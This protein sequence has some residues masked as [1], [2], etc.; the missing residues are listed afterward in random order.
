MKKINYILSVIFLLAILFSCSYDSP[1]SGTDNRLL[2]LNLTVDGEAYKGVMAKGN[3]VNITVPLELDLNAAKVHY[4]IS[5]EARIL[6]DP[7]KVDDWNNDQVFNVIA[8]NGKKR[9]YIVRII[10]QKVIA[11]NDVLLATDEQVKEF[12]EKGISGVEGNLII[13]RES[14]IDSVSNI[15]A[16]TYLKKVN[17]KIIVNPTY[18]GKDLAGLRNVTEMGGLQIIDNR[19]VKNLTLKSLQV[20][21]EDIVIKGDT[22]KTIYFPE[23]KEIKGSIDIR[24]NAI[25]GLNFRKL[26]KTGN[27]SLR[28]SR[29]SI[30]KAPKMKMVRGDF[31]LDKLPALERVDLRK[32]ERIDGAFTIMGL[33]RL[34]TLSLPELKSIGNSFLMKNSSGISEFYLMALEEAKMI[35]IQNNTKLSRLVVPNLKKVNGDFVITACPLRKLNQVAVQ[36]IGG[37]LSLVNLTNIQDITPFLKSIKNVQ[38]INLTFLLLDG[39]LDLSDIVFQKLNIDN[40][41]NLVEIVLPPKLTTFKLKGNAAFRYDKIPNIKGLKSVDDFSIENIV[42]KKALDYT[43]PDLETVGNNFIIKIANIN[44]LHLAKLKAVKRTF[45]LPCVSSIYQHN[46]EGEVSLNTVICPLLESVK[47]IFIDSPDLESVDFPKLSTVQELRVV[48]YYPVNNNSKLKNLNGF[49]ALTSLTSVETKNLK[50]FTDYSFL[51]TVVENG[52]LKKVQSQKNKY[53]PT[54]NDLKAGKYV[55]TQQ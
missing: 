35:T 18:K 34:G 9:T 13:G 17:Y 22:I 50:E 12:A 7:V 5:E 8:Y 16:L 32:L 45:N 33:S 52:S 44:V 41:S 11:N 29:L 47:S 14:G 46:H 21:Y 28:G 26:Q 48:S 4:T 40:C 10:R 24:A 15:D 42:T 39:T 51:K 30:L 1:F 37:K 55:Q 53:N 54:L 31:V 20:V 3:V 43:L 23:V 25:T 36:T 6:P 2:S 38:A 27:L 49:K 19:F